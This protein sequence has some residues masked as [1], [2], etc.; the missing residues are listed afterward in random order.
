VRS[1]STI[2]SLGTGPV[3]KELASTSN[4]CTDTSEA[5]LDWLS[6]GV[7]GEVGRRGRER[8]GRWRGE[9]ER[10][11]ERVKGKE[12]GRENDG[13]RRRERERGGEERGEEER[14]GEVRGMGE[15][16]GGRVVKKGGREWWR[17]KVRIYICGRE[18]SEQWGEEGEYLIDKRGVRSREEGVIHRAKGSIRVTHYLHIYYPF[19][20]V[21]TTTPTTT[22][23]TTTTD[24]N[25]NNR[26]QQL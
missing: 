2:S 22:I 26:Q 13:E 4:P 8:E 25:N 11:G 16:E 23:T 1:R 10:K 21:L 5:S 3:E 14:E 7:E 15:K 20:M 17:K 9:W 18:E 6:C 24:S 12:V 19:P